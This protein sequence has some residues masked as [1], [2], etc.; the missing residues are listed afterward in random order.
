[1]MM[2]LTNSYKSLCHPCAIEMLLFGFV[3]IKIP[4]HSKSETIESQI[5]VS[6]WRNEA[7]SVKFK[8]S[9][10]IVKTQ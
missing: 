6:F 3:P 9:L 2:T 10:I 1:M 8:E 4:T 5:E 7:Q